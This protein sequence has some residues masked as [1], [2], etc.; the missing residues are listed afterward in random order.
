MLSASRCSYAAPPARKSPRRRLSA[1]GFAV[2]VALG[3]FGLSACGN[4]SID[5]T[6]F[7]RQRS[8]L[9]E[10]IIDRS[11]RPGGSATFTF[12]GRVVITS[13]TVVVGLA[14]DAC[15][16]KPF[17]KGTFHCPADY[18]IT[19]DLNYLAG[20]REVASLTVDPSG[21]TSLKG[22]GTVLSPTS[23][24]WADLDTAMGLHPGQ[25]ACNPLLGATAEPVCG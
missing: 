8:S 9:T 22:L 23:R 6:A 2:L 5:G 10:L 4:A 25:G 3:A 17:P 21:C 11:V 14:G 16:L 18:G 1:S 13:R 20:R 15:G 19:Y 7:C 24:F 12:P